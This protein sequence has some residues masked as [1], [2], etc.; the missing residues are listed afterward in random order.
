MPA[1]RVT[2]PN[3][4]LAS[5]RLDAW[6][7]GLV[8]E[9]PEVLGVFLLGSS[10]GA[11]RTPEDQVDLIV[12]LEWAGATEPARGS[13]YPS[14]RL[15]LPFSLTVFSESD[16]SFLAAEASPRLQAALEAGRWLARRAG[17]APPPSG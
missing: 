6:S 17:W 13:T 3:W 16:L 2:R 12:V 14:P 1:E 7:E 9:Y 10:S 15:G 5:D 8:R 11:S 4:E